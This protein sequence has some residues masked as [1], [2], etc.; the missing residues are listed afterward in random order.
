MDYGL[1]VSRPK[2]RSPDCS[3]QSSIIW[4]VCW[5]P[6]YW[7]WYTCVDIHEQGIGINELD[8]KAL[9]ADRELKQVHYVV[10]HNLK[11]L[12]YYKA[13]R[14]RIWV[15]PS[16][17]LSVC[18]SVPSKLISSVRR[19][20]DV[21]STVVR[22]RYDRSTT[23]DYSRSLTN[24]SNKSLYFVFVFNVFLYFCNVFVNNNSNVPVSKLCILN[25]WRTLVL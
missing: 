2:W 7:T 10:Q 8:N 9:C 1:V 18:L 24:R 16:I 13:H 12:S 22:P 23:Y 14:G 19:W 21:D 20:F 5:F 11:I 25:L 3:H 4:E 15:M 6:V 17:R